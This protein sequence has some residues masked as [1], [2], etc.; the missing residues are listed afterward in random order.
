MAEFYST[1]S[2]LPSGKLLMSIKNVLFLSLTAV[3]ILFSSCNN[4]DDSNNFTEEDLSA[5]V[6]V[7]TQVETNVG[8]KAQAIY[9]ALS[10]EEQGQID[11]DFFILIFT[12]AETALETIESCEADDTYVFAASGDI[13]FNNNGTLCEDSQ[14]DDDALFV[15]PATWTLTDGDQLTI[16][17]ADG[18]VTTVTIKTLNSSTLVI[19]GRETFEDEDLGIT[20]NEEIVLSVR[21]TAQ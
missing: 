20:S 6:W 7:A 14:G 15:L 10:A 9:D 4:D 11:E 18:D 8:E 12:F 3:A 19:E 17:D 2:S 5:Q 13:E 16:S 21:F 1:N